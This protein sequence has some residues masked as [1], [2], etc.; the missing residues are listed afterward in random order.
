[1]L[2]ALIIIWWLIVLESEYEKYDHYEII[3]D[4]G[5]GIGDGVVTIIRG[6]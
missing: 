5:E 4:G 2:T 3:P 1:M 6:K